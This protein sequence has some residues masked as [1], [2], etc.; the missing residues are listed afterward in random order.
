MVLV[1]LHSE[2]QNL[3]NQATVV[4]VHLLL[5]DMMWLA[6]HFLQVLLL[7]IMYSQFHTLLLLN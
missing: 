6:Q 5:A 7:I 2:T 1:Q 4:Q 3:P